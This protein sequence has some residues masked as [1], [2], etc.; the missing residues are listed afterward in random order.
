MFEFR[1]SPAGPVLNEYMSGRERVMFIM[2]PMGSGKTF[3]SCMRIFTQ[4]TQ[5]PVDQFGK[6]RSRWVAVR[7]TYP[8]LEGTTMKDWMELFG[9]P[10]LGKMNRDYPPTHYLNFS[11]EDGTYVEAEVI[12]L[13]LDRPDSVRKL[14]GMQCT[15]FWLNE[16]KELDEEIVDMCDL[17]HGRYPNKH[18]VPGYWHGMI[19]DTNAPDD[20]HW[21][22]R[23]AEVDKP[24]GWVFLKQPG[25][26]IQVDTP[27][28]KKWVLNPKAE[29]L[30]NL[31]DDYYTAG[32]QGKKEA[33]IKVNLANMYGH[34]SSGRPIYEHDWNDTTHVSQYPL[35]PLPSK[36]NF[37]M[38]WDFGMT[39]SCIIGQ[40]DGP[41]LRILDEIIGEG[42]GI[43]AF[44]EDYVIPY[45]RQ[46]YPGV[47]LSDFTCYCDPSGDDPRDTEGDSPIEILRGLE[48]EA[49]PSP[50]NNPETRWEAVR[51]FLGRLVGGRPAFLLSPNCDTLR[52]GFNGGYQFK[53][54]QVSGT[55]RYSEKADKNMFSHPHDALQYLCQAARGGYNNLSSVPKVTASGVR[56][57]SKSGY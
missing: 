10:E 44:A 3:G 50:S 19:G 51:Y 12:F 48:F 45:V 28:G 30:Q 7:N 37:Y 9:A 5:Q 34:V 29:N 41:Q 42:V 11:M 18:E 14:R 25:G 46:Q 32:M 39:P 53:R 21:Y 31:P 57:A 26:L 1:F 56:V 36:Q 27:R 24:A 40:M 16:V 6:R 49:E 52:K 43:R 47:K 55:A 20:H 54:M 23:K 17:R 4:I 8:D 13:A 15:G 22:Y 35:V 33:W 2:G 38:G